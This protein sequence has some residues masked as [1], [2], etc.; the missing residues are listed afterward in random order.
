MREQK[1]I[2]SRLSD[3]RGQVIV[4]VVI[5]FV[6][7]TAMVG[8]VIDIGYAYRTQRN[9]Q[10]TAD[11]AAL[12]GAQQ[13]PDSTSATAV[14]TQYGA[15][16]SGNNKVGNVP[17]T[18]SIST[19][20]IT[21]IPGCSPVNSVSVSEAATVPTF[22]SKVLGFTSFKI[23]VKATACSPCG[24]R[25]VDVMLVLDRTGSM[26]QDSTGANDPACT[27]LNNAKDGIRTFLSFFD[28][29]LAW[30]GLAVLP[31][32][33][34][35]SGRCNTP[36]TSNYNSTTAAY[37]IVPMSHDYKNP[38]NSLNT[39]SNLLSTLNCIQGGGS[40]SYSNAI[41]AAQAELDAHGRAGVPDVI[42]FMS[43][44]AANTG[45][46]YYSTSSPYRTQPCHQGATSA[47]FSKVKGTTVYSIG[48]AL[49]D[50]TGGCRSY[51]GSAESP[52]ITVTQALTN[53]ATDP[54]HFFLKPNPG[55]LQGIYSAIANDIGHGASSLIG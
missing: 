49:N 42:V 33:T 15:S 19:S 23:K 55:S 16:A 30:V 39:S 50:D 2:L 47:G 40:T 54:S 13:L 14:A 10:A 24:S 26:C 17:V 37:T 25:P 18:E 11:A 36:A 8:V 21:T 41:E 9:L 3:E 12:A 4:F 48:Y 43:D 46:T 44:G 38:D 52:A 35:V 6:V 5:A 51:T 1:P 29:N 28:P 31:P 53:I 45:P 32:A 34:S 20:C 27:D 7:L 22:F